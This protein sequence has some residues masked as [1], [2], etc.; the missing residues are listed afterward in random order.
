[1][2]E[3]LDAQPA[4]ERGDVL[5]RCGRAPG[6]QRGDDRQPHDQDRVETLTA[7]KEPRARSVGK[8]TLMVVEGSTTIATAAARRGRL[9]MR[10]ALVLSLAAPARAQTA[11]HR[12]APA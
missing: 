9:L 4:K 11:P 10:C 6:A 7:A 12:G 2:M 8:T 5:E 1:R 3:R